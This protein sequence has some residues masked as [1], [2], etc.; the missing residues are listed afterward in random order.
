[1]SPLSAAIR[2]PVASGPR[3]RRLVCPS[4]RDFGGAEAFRSDAGCTEQSYPVKVWER[5]IVRMPRNTSPG[6]LRGGG[7][8][9]SLHTVRP[10][11]PLS[12]QGGRGRVCIGWML[13]LGCQFYI[14]I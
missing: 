10:Y 9:W 14:L 8:L 6:H 2:P 4:A 1:M 11:L 3:V 12:R 7:G 5:R 13:L